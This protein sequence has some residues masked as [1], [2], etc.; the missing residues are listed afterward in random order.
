MNY[1]VSAEV[2]SSHAGVLVSAAETS[3]PGLGQHL[4]PVRRVL[5][6]PTMNVNMVDD[7]PA[8]L[9]SSVCVCEC[10]H[11]PVHVASEVNLRCHSSGAI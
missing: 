10:V 6:Q 5:D 4:Q 11:A 3:L 1:S 7:R 2:D 8:S 9:L